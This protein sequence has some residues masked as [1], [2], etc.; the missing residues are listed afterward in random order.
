MRFA[1]G[2]QKLLAQNIANLTTP[3]Y[4]TQ[5]VSPEGFQRMLG[6]AVDQRRAR[7]GGS[8]GDLE[9][10]G[11]REIEQDRATGRLTLKPKAGSGNIVFHDRNDRDLERS[12]QALVENASYFRAATDF[13]RQQKNQLMVA[14]TERV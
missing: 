7:N 12:M 2:R 8:F 11:S 10:T 1:S 13:M 6:E 5:D 9:L 3:N 14:I 4:Q